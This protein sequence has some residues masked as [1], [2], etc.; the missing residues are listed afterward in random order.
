MI[1]GKAAAAARTAAAKKRSEIG[2]DYLEAAQS[3]I[4]QLQ[5]HNL[6]LE[7]QVRRLKEQLEAPE[8]EGA[9]SA[10]PERTPAGGGRRDRRR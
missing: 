9:V 7:A 6:R 1:D 4:R 8:G 2:I 3:R 10:P 5:A